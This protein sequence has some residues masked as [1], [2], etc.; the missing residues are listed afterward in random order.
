MKRQSKDSLVQAEKRTVW[1]SGP[2]ASQNG[3]MWETHL[4]S[5]QCQR[6]VS[7]GGRTRA[8]MRVLSTVPVSGVL[9]EPPISSNMGILHPL[10]IILASEE[11]VLLS[12][13]LWVSGHLLVGSVGRKQLGVPPLQPALFLLVGGC[14]QVH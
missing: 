14:W 11:R 4:K 10:Q 5:K 9:L 12:Q 3:G 1:Q 2:L 6:G 13:D 7:P 8:G